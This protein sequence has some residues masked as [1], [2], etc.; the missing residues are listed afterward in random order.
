MARAH[1]K[2]NDMV[3][4]IA[5][6]DNGRSGKILSVDPVKQRVVVEG[7]NRRKKAVRR[8][9]DNPQ[10][11]IV[12]REFPIHASNVML[13]EKYD[14]RRGRSGDGAQAAAEDEVKDDD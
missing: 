5:G 6:A 1:V 12:E 9:Q 2:K 13:K 14:A 4:V 10:G 3:T 8:S 7:I 11:G